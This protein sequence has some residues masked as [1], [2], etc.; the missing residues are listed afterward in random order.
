MA[1]TLEVG[2]IYKFQYAGKVLYFTRDNDYINTLY[3]TSITPIAGNFS[4]W[5][6]ICMFWLD[7]LKYCIKVEQV[8]KSFTILYGGK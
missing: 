6:N 5:S 2:P 3:E 4:D 1:K 7:N 8:P